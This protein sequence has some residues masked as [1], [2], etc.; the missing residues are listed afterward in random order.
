MVHKKVLKKDETWVDDYGNQA[1]FEAGLTEEQ[2][3]TRLAWM[4]KHWR[5]VV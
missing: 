5:K 4:G 3:N 1:V 2:V